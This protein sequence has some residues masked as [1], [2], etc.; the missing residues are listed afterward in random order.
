LVN[1]QSISPLIYLQALDL[2]IF[3]GKNKNNERGGMLM[4][5]QRSSL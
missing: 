1:F 2:T 5:E 3:L 4:K